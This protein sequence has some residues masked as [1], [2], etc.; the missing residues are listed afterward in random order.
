MTDVSPLS[1]AELKRLQDYSTP[2]LSNAIE[3]FEVRPRS[4][5]Y[6]N[7]AIRCLQPLAKPMVGYAA[8][9]RFRC[10]EPAGAGE[11]ASRYEFWDWLL[12]IPEPRVVVLQDLD[13]PPAVGSFWGEIMATIHMALGCVGTVTNGGVRDLDEVR[14]LGFHYFAAQVVVS[15]AYVHLVDFGTPVA[16]GGVTVRSGEL[17]HADQHGV[18]LIPAEVAPYLAEVAEAYEGIEQEFL[19]RVRAPGLDLDRLRAE[20]EVFH[21]R[22]SALRPPPGYHS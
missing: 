9:G 10:A 16:V 12:R 8:T 2:T 11:A 20:R 19:R 17:I 5:G 15:H 3:V 21:T 18:L 13:E 7:A 6:M 22:R 14:A 4:E 1:A